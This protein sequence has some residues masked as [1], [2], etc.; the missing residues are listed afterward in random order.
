LS[1]SRSVLER[2]L[3]LYEWYLPLTRSYFWAPV[4]Y[5]FFSARF[6]IDQVLL[7]QSIYYA[8]VVVLEVPS[9]YLSDRVSRTLT[10]RLSA[11][12]GLLSFSLFVFG[13]A[14]FELFV[15]AQ[16]VQ[17]VSF[18][19][20]SGTDV[21]L[22]YDTL[23]GL[24]RQDEFGAR[25]ARLG[26]RALLFGS[27]SALIG[28]LVAIA[29]LRW[30]YVLSWVVALILIPVVVAMREPPRQP[31]PAGHDFVRQLRACAG[32]L[33]QPLLAWLFAFV[34]LQTSLEHVPY[35][36][37]QPYM[38]AVL[39]ETATRVQNTPLASG[40]VTA[41][42]AFVA[43]FAVRR[44]IGLRNRFGLGRLLLGVT[45]LQTLI[46]GLMGMVYH[47]LVVPLILLR[48][49]YPAISR[50]LVNAAIAPRVPELQRATYLSL[51]SLAG[52]LG[53]AGVLYTLSVIGSGAENDP[54][55]VAAMLRWCT[56]L[57]LVGTG[58]LALTRGAVHD[59]SSS[60]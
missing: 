38:A 2:N 18:S 11:M 54:P 58:A 36:F 52:R 16:I 3:R 26:S 34:V 9:G 49:C 28:G 32:F 15:A 41:G 40:A 57:A 10:L 56:G 44:S 6:P 45:A 60:K 1:P 20:A 22:H 50:V 30:A 24:G 47:A 5:L 7:L 25:E 12:A 13:G 39:G 27:A 19:F 43:A 48:S 4:F 55:T 42:I 29:D 59:E 23:I 51:H 17:A 31:I 33:R 37:A 21:S 14:E 53:Y 8:T 46:I 35:E